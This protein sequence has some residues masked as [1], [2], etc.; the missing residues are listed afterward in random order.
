MPMEDTR[1][2]DGRGGGIQGDTPSMPVVCADSPHLGLQRCKCENAKKRLL[3]LFPNC[4]S[5]SA[6]ETLP[7]HDQ[8]AKHEPTLTRTRR[9]MQSRN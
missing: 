7:L 3:C 2:G 8:E 6:S 4:K 1:G 5:I 9:H